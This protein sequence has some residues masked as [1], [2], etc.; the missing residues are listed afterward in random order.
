MEPKT[1][2]KTRQQLEKLKHFQ[3]LNMPSR[4]SLFG[5]VVE[6]LV[7]ASLLAGG[8]LKETPAS[9]IWASWLLFGMGLLLFSHSLFLIFRYYYDKRFIG[10]LEQVLTEPDESNS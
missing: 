9:V 8:I 4:F 7:G 1:I 2:I 10:L 5:F 6:F 3:T